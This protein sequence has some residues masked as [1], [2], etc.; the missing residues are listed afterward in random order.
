MTISAKNVTI[1]FVIFIAAGVVKLA[2]TLD[3]G[4]SARACRFKSCRLHQVETLHVISWRVFF[5]SAEWEYKDGAF[6]AEEQTKDELVKIAK[7]R[8]ILKFHFQA[9]G[10]LDMS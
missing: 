2:D 3:L 1:S 6:T 9:F 8:N 4:S 10:R 5:Y 7:E